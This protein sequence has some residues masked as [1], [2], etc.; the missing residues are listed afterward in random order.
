M[1]Q[2]NVVILAAGKGTRMVSDTPKVLHAIAGQPIL[3]HVIS[4]AKALS[5]SKIIVVYGFGGEQVKEA[6]A[7]EDIIWVRQA[8]QLGTG[9]AVQQVVAYLDVDATTL[10]LLG[11]VPLVDAISCQQL[12]LKAQDKLALLSFKK[13]DP[14]GYGRIVRNT[15][16]KVI[17]IVEHKDASVEQRSIDEVNTGIMAMPSRLLISW[18]A[19][20][21]NSNA[22]SEYYLTDIVGFA[23]QDGVDVDAELSLDKYAQFALNPAWN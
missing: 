8:E 10:I 12:L 6:F 15:Q 9:H 2:L 18:L 5:A 19:R 4:C 17:A 1:K 14:S 11:D 21:S 23:V 20:L 3:Q 13:P 7:H 16:D 22:Q